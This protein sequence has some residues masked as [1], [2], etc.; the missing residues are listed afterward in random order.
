M[1]VE[2]LLKIALLGSAWVLWLLLALSVLSVGQIFERWLYFRKRS[3]DA[4]RLRRSLEE[5][6]L[7]DDLERAK[8]VLAKSPAVEA[9]VVHRA[10]RWKAGGPRA[11]GDAVESELSAAR[12]DLERGMNLLGTLGS[13]APFIGLFGTVIGVIEAF[14][15]LGSSAAR[16]GAMG[17]VMAGIAEALVATAVGIFVAVPA[18]VAY[19]VAQKR[20]G[21][22]ETSASA[23]ARLVTAWLET[24]DRRAAAAPGE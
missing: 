22:V 16:G 9:G 14:N 7:A 2:K 8:A 1:I 18:V 20:I 6:L 10:L 11:F 19:N 24:N 5:A 13:N 17:N 23:L 3:D 15:H 12:A 4:E 21:E